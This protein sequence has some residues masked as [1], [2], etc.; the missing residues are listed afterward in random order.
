[1]LRADPVGPR[2]TYYDDATGERIELSA[3]TLANWAAK[4]GNLLRDEL[5]AGPASR[6]AILLP[7]HW[8][9][10]AVLF[11]AWWIGAETLLGPADPTADLALCTVEHHPIID[12]RLAGCPALRKELCDGEIRRGSIPEVVP[13]RQQPHVGVALDGGLRCPVG[14]PVVGQHHADRAVGGQR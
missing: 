3:A 8:Q 1:M 7:A 11:G 6:I 13:G 12:P 9:T 10:T 5:A 14:G 4:T 2:I